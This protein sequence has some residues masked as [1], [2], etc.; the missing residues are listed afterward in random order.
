MKF[1]VCVSILLICIYLIG[2]FSLSS[3]KPVRPD[4]LKAHSV[5]HTIVSSEKT[6]HPISESKDRTTFFEVMG[7]KISIKEL[8]PTLVKD[9]DNDLK[10]IE[11]KVDVK[12]ANKTAEKQHFN[13]VRKKPNN[14]NSGRRSVGLIIS[15]NKM[16]DSHL[17][18]GIIAEKVT[19]A[20]A[21]MARCREVPGMA[22]VLVKE[23]EAVQIPV[24]VADIISGRAVTADTRFL[25]NSI[26]K[27]FLGQLL[28][29]LITQS[30]GK[31]TWDTKVKDILG[32][33]FQLATEE[34][35]KEVTLRDLLSHRSGLSSGNLAVRAT[36]PE[37]WTTSDVVS[38]MKH[39][40]V[41]TPFRTSFL[42]SNMGG[43]LL[44]L[45]AETLGGASWDKLIVDLLLTPLSMLDSKPLTS[46]SDFESANFSRLYVPIEGKLRVA[47]NRIF[48]QGPMA[49]VAL[50]STTASDMTKWLKFN[51]RK[52]CLS[53]GRP[54][55]HPDVW[56]DMW[57]KQA[58]LSP[59]FMAGVDK[60]GNEWP[61]RDSSQGY[62]LF[63]FIN[64]YRGLTNYWHGGG[65]Y[66]HYTLAWHFPEKDVALYTVINGYS[67][68]VKPFSVVEGLSYY[69]ADLLL[70]YQ[71]WLE[72]KY[73]CSYPQPLLKAF[74]GNE[75][76]ARKA[77]RKSKEKEQRREEIYGKNRKVQAGDADKA[78]IRTLRSN[79]PTFKQS[80]TT[81]G[82][83][84]EAQS[85][86]GNEGVKFRKNILQQTNLSQ[87]N[88]SIGTNKRYSISDGILVT[89][90]KMQISPFADRGDIHFHKSRY[91]GPKRFTEFPLLPLEAYKGLYF[92]PLFGNFSVSLNESLKSLQCRM[93][94]LSG[95][96]HPLKSHTF[97]VELTGSLRF[98]SKPSA[99]AAA[100]DAFLIDF[101][102]S[103][104]GVITAVN[105][106]S[107]WPME[108]PLTFFRIR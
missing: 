102:E 23:G 25:L 66:T 37:G 42:Y 13:T 46:S 47:D 93:R 105:V 92:N 35:T 10:T 97:G 16:P 107:S 1:V 65:L 63:W 43:I 98:L 74:A 3:R 88:F 45:V 90:R 52:G 71:P 19:L 85:G 50:L 76:N 80:E 101:L 49:A 108:V 104:S 40:P 4:P 15:D 75:P 17:D 99:A 83:E 30:D 79:L 100:K 54:L 2:P 89:S 95:T 39:L 86:Q 94:V 60:S 48:E 68:D 21:R 38:R 72:E 32:P 91:K 6:K 55:I 28:A 26:S 78:K 27:S 70:G 14:G 77:Q 31:L 12:N 73:L 58:D 41:S 36:L 44:A 51:L 53:S 33:T 82:S 34:L 20:A 106:H 57:K 96:L 64:R 59:M 18:L 61:V 24:G 9:F 7:K 11:D 56:A 103:T 67:G 8:S 5:E 29:V 87:F 22:I 84:S 62:G 81:P 69:A